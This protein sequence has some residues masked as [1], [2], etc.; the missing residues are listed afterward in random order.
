MAESSNSTATNL[1]ELRPVVLATVGGGADVTTAPALFSDRL[2]GHRLFCL[3][4]GF[5]EE[6]CFSR[7]GL[8]LFRAG[9]CRRA[10][11]HIAR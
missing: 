3:Q 6:R 9:R 7:G 1:R 10:W 5:D 4:R 11:H 8:H 2:L